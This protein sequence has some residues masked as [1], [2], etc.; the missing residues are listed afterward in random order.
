MTQIARV[1]RSTVATTA[2][3]VL[4]VVAS[5]CAAQPKVD[6]VFALQT[7]AEGADPGI[8]QYEWQRARTRIAL[9]AEWYTE[10]TFTETVALYGLVEL[11]RSGGFGAEVRYRRWMNRWLGGF[12]G[13]TAILQP[14]SLL[15]A[16]GGATAI[17]G[18]GGKAA[19]FAELSA[20]AFPLGTDL[21]HG[22]S[23]VT[24]LSLGA[25]VRLGF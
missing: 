21:P 23:V 18:L 25:G 8:G 14:E 17:Y 9:G 2:C 3:A 10:H 1:R 15:G 20:S 24:W 5:P 6:G 16:T 12:V 19:I 13:V 11:E 22:D 4:L 7:G